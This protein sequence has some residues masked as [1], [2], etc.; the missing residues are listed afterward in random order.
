MD[1]ATG[2]QP[3]ALFDAIF[4]MFCICQVWPEHSKRA[5]FISGHNI[6]EAV[7]ETDRHHLLHWQIDSFLDESSFLERWA[8]STQWAH[9]SDGKTMPAMLKKEIR[10]TG[11]GHRR[12][13]NWW[14]HTPHVRIWSSPTLYCSS[15]FPVVLLLGQSPGRYIR[16]NSLW[17]LTDGLCS[18]AAYLSVTMKT[19][20]L[21][22][23][24]YSTTENK[25][26]IDLQR[27][28]Q[29]WALFLLQKHNFPWSFS[30]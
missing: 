15:P 23:R 10:F 27:K 6:K 25:E 9:L 12:L 7:S 5:E 16:R 3:E 24:K 8:M 14:V 2:F 19:N 17:Q 30:I 21:S 18:P 13:K 4:H 28:A 29:C 26:T 20:K 1:W 22:L 11:E